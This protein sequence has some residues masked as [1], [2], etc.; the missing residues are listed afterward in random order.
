MQKH[1]K[2]LLNVG[3]SVPVNSLSIIRGLV[4]DARERIRD[5]VND[6]N[7]YTKRMKHSIPGKQLFMTFGSDPGKGLQLRSQA[8]VSLH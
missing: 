7:T 1:Q 6:R 3:Y 5:E 8:N 4:P 2:Y